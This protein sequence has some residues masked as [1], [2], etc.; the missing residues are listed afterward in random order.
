[1]TVL[2]IFTREGANCCSKNTKPLSVMYSLIENKAIFTRGMLY[3]NTGLNKK[4]LEFIK[5]I[6]KDAYTLGQKNP[7]TELEIIEELYNV[8]EE[9]PD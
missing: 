9:D 6:I 7:N 1:M 4:T 5:D 2:E 3:A 8:D